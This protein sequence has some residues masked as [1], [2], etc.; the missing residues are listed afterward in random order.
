MQPTD[1]N[2]TKP[3]TGVA[4]ARLLLKRDLGWLPGYPLELRSGSLAWRKFNWDAV[5]GGHTHTINRESIRAAQ[6]SLTKL[7]YRFPRALPKVV[8]DP[9]DWLGRMEFLLEALKGWLQHDTTADFHDILQCEHIPKRW[10]DRFE[11]LQ[12]RHRQLDDFLLAVASIQLTGQQPVHGASIEWIDRHASTLIKLLDVQRLQ[13]DED[14]I[15]LQLKF[16]SLGDEAPQGLL[17]RFAEILSTADLRNCFVKRHDENVTRLFKCVWQASKQWVVKTPEYAKFQCFGDHLSRLIDRAI[18]AT[19]K[20][21][22][23][24]LELVDLVLDDAAINEIRTLH[25]DVRNEEARLNKALQRVRRTKDPSFEDRQLVKAA[26]ESRI[27]VDARSRKVT[28]L[29]DCL[30]RI[31]WMDF[32]QMHTWQRFIE[33]LPANRRDIRIGLFHFWRDMRGLENVLKQLTP[34]VSTTW[35]LPLPAGRLGAFLYRGPTI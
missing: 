13:P 27:N 35:R 2:R 23:R 19:P 25:A 6:M 3:Q 11:N 30:Q 14:V 24:L 32:D 12:Q 7:R 16:F 8:A 28:A 1:K 20:Q 33:S 4:R 29:A 17:E 5:D 21:R 26:C 31:Q 22:R 15:Q 18:R 9:D 34:P 10:L